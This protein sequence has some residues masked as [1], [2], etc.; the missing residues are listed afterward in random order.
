MIYTCTESTVIVQDKVYD[1][2]DC[3]FNNYKIRK[4]TVGSL[5]TAYN[6]IVYIASYEL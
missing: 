3:R 1:A 5:S 4:L 6:I 2:H